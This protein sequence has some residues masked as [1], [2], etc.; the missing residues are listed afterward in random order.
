[1]TSPRKLDMEI[2]T[3]DEPWSVVTLTNGDKIKSPLLT[4]SRC[5]RRSGSR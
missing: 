5:M 3:T 1:M 4:A 2:K